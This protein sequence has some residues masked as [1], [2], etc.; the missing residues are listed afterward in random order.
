MFGVGIRSTSFLGAINKPLPVWVTSSGRL[1]RSSPGIY[2]T[3]SYSTTVNATFA[4]SYS[5][6]SG[7]LPSGMSL[8]S[9]TGVISGV[10]SGV[11]NYT[12]NNLYNF[13]I[14]ATNTRGSVDRSFEIR[15]DSYL[16]GRTCMEMDE[17]QSATVTAPSG[18]TFTQVAFSSYG[19]PTGSCPNYA[20]SGCH[21]GA[22]PGQLAANQY[23]RTSVSVSAT[24][25]AF[26]DPCG[27]T[28]KRYRGAFAYSPI[29]P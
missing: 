25:A 23:P 9:S 28:F 13:T 27:G 2:T 10:P 14:R 18:F 26:G 19:T 21:S 24:N 15:V 4:Q 8:N 22:R 29:N 7:S 3:V 20:T 16:V 6:V 17:N 1:F 12:S 11:S 5:V